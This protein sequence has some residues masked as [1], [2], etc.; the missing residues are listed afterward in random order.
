M[1]SLSEKAT[2]SLNSA[3]LL[4][5]EHYYSSTVN[6]SYYACFQYLMHVLFEKL[7][8]S[9][10][11]FYNEVNNGKNGT[12]TW[13]SKLISFELAKKDIKD[14]KWYQKEIPALRAKRIEADY[15]N[16]EISSAE[17]HDSINKAESIMNLLA[18]H[19]K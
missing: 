17:G 15:H 9:P 5:R 14:Y 16:I 18:R 4:V 1:A 8:K 12:H 2:Q 19:F 11:E 13:A 10:T 3:R 7:K 6:R